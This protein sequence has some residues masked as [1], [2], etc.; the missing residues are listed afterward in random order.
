MCE[1]DGCITAVRRF[2]DPIQS[3]RGAGAGLEKYGGAGRERE[4]CGAET[5]RRVCLQKE[6]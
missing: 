6:M 4:R 2:L 5:E 1:S 3:V